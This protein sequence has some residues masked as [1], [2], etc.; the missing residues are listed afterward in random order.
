MTYCHQ[1]DWNR[2]RR[3]SKDTF[4]V[5]LEFSC[6]SLAATA[7]HTFRFSAVPI[8]LGEARI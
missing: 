3:N 7:E 2:M 5:K 1:T 4:S 6:G 8:L